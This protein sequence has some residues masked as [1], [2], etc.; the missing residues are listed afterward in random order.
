[1]LK[2]DTIKDL[3]RLKTEMERKA[4]SV[5]SELTRIEG[6]IHA[7]DKP[8]VLGLDRAVVSILRQAEVQAVDG[9][10]YVFHTASGKH[11]DYYPIWRRIKQKAGLPKLF[12]PHDLRHTF[13]SYL[14]SSREVDIYTR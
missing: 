4:D 2:D 12:R 5:R 1:M 9:S 11:L 8:I 13:A 3:V 10:G 14:A 7:L 6:D